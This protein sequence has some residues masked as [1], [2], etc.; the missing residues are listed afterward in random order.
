MPLSE[1]KPVRITLGNIS[2]RIP[3]KSLR[4]D[5]RERGLLDSAYDIFYAGKKKGSQS[6]IRNYVDQDKNEFYNQSYNS[7]ERFF[8]I[9]FREDGDRHEKLPELRAHIAA[10]WKNWCETSRINYPGMMGFFLEDAELNSSRGSTVKEIRA[11]LTRF[12]NTS[13]PE[14]QAEALTVLTLLSL[15]RRQWE[16]VVPEDILPGGAD[17]NPAASGTEAEQRLQ[18]AEQIFQHEKYE[19]CI[20][21]L[22]NLGRYR[23]TSGDSDGIESVYRFNSRVFYL[24]SQSYRENRKQYQ[25]TDPQYQELTD[26]LRFALEE[27][28]ANHSV[29]A[30]LEAARDYFGRRP[31]SIYTP[32]SGACMHMCRKLI[33]TDPEDLACGEAYWMLHCLEAD[34][35]ASEEHLKKAASYSYP[36]AVR[37]WTERNAVSLI[38]AIGKS[39][40]GT[41]GA[42]Y[43]NEDNLYSRLICKTAPEGWTKER[44][45][46][47]R[48]Y[49]LIN[50]DSDQNLRELLHLLQDIKEKGNAVPDGQTEFFIRGEEEKI[51]PFIDTA[52]A[53]MGNRVI[54]VHILDDSK[55]AARVLARHPLFFPIRRLE[56]DRKAQ[57]N[58]IVVGSSRCC[59]WLVREAFW[60][61]TFR[62]PNIST[63]IRI[64]GPDADRV[65][66]KLDFLCPELAEQEDIIPVSCLYESPEFIRQIEAAMEAGA[67][68]YYAVDAG[69]DTANAALA[70]RI[71]EITIRERLNELQK[72][73]QPEFP[74]V[75]FH[76]QDPD[77]ASLSRS[78]VVINEEFGTDWFNNYALIPFGR[79]DQQ[80]HWDAMTGDI[81]EFLSLNIHL[82]YYLDQDF[83]PRSDPKAYEAQYRNA[84]RDFY[85]RTYNRD[86]SLAV[87]MSLPYR[88]YQ[89]YTG[90]N[91]PILPDASDSPDA[92]KLD[93]LDPDTFFSETAR[94]AYISQIRKAGWSSAPYLKEIQ[95]KRQND[96]YEWMEK[97]EDYDTE[98]ELYR[99]A[100]WEHTRWNRFMI[101]RGWTK[102]SI[103]QMR[104][105]YRK[106]NKRQQLFIGRM[107]PCITAFDSLPSVDSAWRGLTEAEKDFRLNDISSIRMT[108]HILGLEW[109]RAAGKYFSGKA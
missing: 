99:L 47:C 36:E 64:L 100:E 28:I 104:L 105:Y 67:Y 12:R 84:L 24:L 54:P 59:E 93:I 19:K 87:A 62:N 6:K 96:F 16:R 101:S 22:E 63:S 13:D 97:V 68:A 37:K 32:D 69:S 29:P 10:F 7:A 78:T 83:D 43:I 70:M 107:H 79:I 25:E 81:L 31:D 106:R 60:L 9:Y 55:M 90:R 76:C 20:E 42:F 49:F 56:K 5:E 17:R 21:I 48:K 33:S 2:R 46:P 11:F 38:Q 57:L 94:N 58:F 3:E 15:T 75:A 27:A 39:A 23:D 109:T 44:T 52:L 14:E 53:R 85:G 98:S 45:G 18:E 26:S 65:K 30:M 72:E 8:Q 80:Y 66:E 50:D 91:L 35:R 103:Q 92:R 34:D 95:Q 86:S 74:V 41:S 88:L 61:L 102:A 108:E 51:S 4:L 73:S 89:G 1:K 77:I 82:Q 40:A 71:R